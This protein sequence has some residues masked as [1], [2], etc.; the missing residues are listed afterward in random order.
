MSCRPYYLPY[1]DRVAAENLLFNSRRF[2]AF[3]FRKSSLAGQFVLSTLEW[4]KLGPTHP[5]V[6]EGLVPWALPPI[7]HL[8]TAEQVRDVE[9]IGKLF[10]LPLRPNPYFMAIY[11]FFLTHDIRGMRLDLI[12]NGFLPSQP[13]PTAAETQ[14]TCKDG[15]IT[16]FIDQYHE[17]T[18]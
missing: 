9:G 1:V 4:D 10:N 7:H 2:G 11:K 13:P 18:K 6:A 17:R 3:L 12:R 16:H 15:I 14:I 5:D 8:I